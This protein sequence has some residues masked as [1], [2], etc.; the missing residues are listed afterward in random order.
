[1]DMAIKIFFCYAH[2]DEAL[3]SKLK[4]HLRPLQRQGFIDVWYDSDIIAG[5]EWEREIDKHLNAAK[6]ILLLVSP[7]FMD[8][9]HCYT[10]MQHALE[11]HKN[12][13]CRVIPILLRPTNWKEA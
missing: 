12:R 4:T 8:S 11:Q 3:L 7:D 6:V 5:A 2:E 13:A 10:E 9:D 1:M